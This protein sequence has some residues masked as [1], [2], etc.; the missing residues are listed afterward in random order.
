MVTRLLLLAGLATLVAA[1]AVVCGVGDATPVAPLSEE[2]VVAFQKPCAEGQW[3]EGRACLPL[4][5]A[6]AP[7]GT[8][9]VVDARNPRASDANT[10][11]SASP[12]RTIGRAAQQMQPGDAVVI[13]AGVYRESLAP[14]RG[15]TDAEH[16]ITYAAAPGA[17]VVVSG[18]DPVPRG[19]A[20]AGLSRWRR[21]WPAAPL[22]TYA[23]DPV[24]R[25][26]LVVARGRVMRPVARVRDLAPGQVVIDGPPEAPSMMTVHLPL[27]VHPDEIEVATRERLFWPAAS[28]PGAPCGDASQASWL[29][30]AGITFVHAA[31][32]AQ[33]GAVC[34]GR[35]HGLFEDVT[36]AGTVGM[37]VDVGGRDHVFRR[38][39]SSDHGQ[40]GWGGGCR[41]CLFED[42]S[43]RRNNWRGFDPFWEAGG[44][45]WVGTTDTVIRRHVAEDNGGPGIWLDGGNA[46]NTIEGCRVER[47]EVAGIMLELDTVETLV[48]H[49]VVRGT[50]W[51]EWS[52]S[53]I[54][55]QA[56]SRNALWHNTV[57]DNDGI[58]VWL[59]LDPLR[60]A[61]DVGTRVEANWIV[62]NARGADEAREIAVEAETPTLVRSHAFANN[63]YGQPTGDPTLI[64]SFFLA[65]LAGGGDYRGSDV[66]TW[67][68]LSGETGARM[69]ALARTPVRD[70]LAPTVGAPGAPAVPY[71]YAGADPA[72]VAP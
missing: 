21:S 69:V 14:P 58:G 72:R 22:P 16:R 44:G 62:G 9:Y 37:G 65:P 12:W 5:D 45:K 17:R 64:S 25:R 55:S 28:Q 20:P 68:P 42:T 54:L 63:V 40:L 56:A 2:P 8:L 60:R 59:R 32:R 18:A 67:M 41:R 34:A 53:G 13:T 49:N 33:W 70:G 39:E 27:G 52:G 36:I 3:R 66:G 48:Q 26:E 57:V 47:N 15:G 1:A 4:A 31:N 6:L 24:F 61:P 23:D 19:W 35:A 10:G 7:N 51:R 46:R 29:R 11:T 30:V 43:A 71:G 38:V 50:R